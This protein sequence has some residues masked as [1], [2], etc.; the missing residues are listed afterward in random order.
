MNEEEILELL[1]K[2][3]AIEK[4]HFKLSSGL[5]SD[6]YIQCAALLQYPEVTQKLAA[7]LAISYKDKKIDTVVS[8]AIGGIVLGYAV[9]QELGCR[10]IWAERQSG[11]M[12]FKRGFFL[13]NGEKVLVVED[14]IT[15]GGS[16]KEIIDLVEEAD[17][18]IIDVAAIIDRGDQKVFS[19]PINSLLKLEIKSFFP[20][21]CSLCSRGISFQTPGSRHRAT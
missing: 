3:G 16:V 7:E 8:P 21:E 15:T 19:H 9:A 14:V 2:R 10:A 13:D 12:V 18:I 1:K 5:H 11:K 4:G 17:A 6:T 20:E